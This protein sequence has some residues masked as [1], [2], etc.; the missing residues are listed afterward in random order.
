MFSNTYIKPD[1][2]FRILDVPAPLAAPGQFLPLFV[3]L[4]RKEYDIQKVMVRGTT[5]DTSDQISA[6]DEI[7][8]LLSSILDTNGISYIQGTDFQLVRVSDTYSVDWNL[9]QSIVGTAAET[10]LITAGVNDEL[11]LKVNGVSYT[12]PITAGPTQAAADIANDINGVVG[13]SIAADD[14]SGHVKL[15]GNSIVFDGNSSVMATIGFT[16]DQSCISK[17]PLAGVSYTL[18]YKRIKKASEYKQYYFTRL[19]DVYA[20]QGAKVT[21][22]VIFNQATPSGVTSA[23]NTLTATLADTGATFV[24]DGVEPGNYIK[25][26]DGT[27]KGQIR[28]ITEVTSETALV[29]GPLWDIT[30]NS[31]SKYTITNY[32]QYQISNACNFANINGAQAFMISQTPDDIIDDNNWKLAVSRTS[33]NVDGQQGWCL[34]PLMA[35]DVNESFTSYIKSYINTVNT[36]AGN[37]ERMALLGIKQGLTVS[38]VIS[39][40]NGVNDERHGIITNPYATDDNDVVFGAEY[41]AAAISGIICNPD[42]DAGEPISGKVIQGFKFIYN[43]YNT[44]ESRQIG[45]NGGILIEKQGVDNKIVHFLSTNSSDVI[46]VELKVIKQKDSIKKSLR[47]ILQTA[48]INTRALDIALTRADSIVRMVLDDKV[49]KTEIAEYDNLSIE[50]EPTDPRQMNISF[51]FKPT[52]D[53]NWI[54]VTFGAHI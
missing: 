51:R 39:F 10:F 24:T 18:A 21:P 19:E 49:N 23:N 52:F 20:D 1:V 37:K 31:T 13:S 36:T 29:V 48:L 47:S 26:V 3:G 35:L 17:E 6:N 53:I 28:V 4:G 15:T 12:I 40:L 54:L 42:Y 11:K 22:T 45:Q 2:Y 50:F 32:G 41:I 34:V 38:Q 5:P 14:G 7:V 8:V 27:G 30:P 46:K 33:E 16:P 25:I 43:G 44:Y 9:P